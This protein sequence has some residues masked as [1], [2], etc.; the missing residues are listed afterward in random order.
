MSVL[1]NSK[2]IRLSFILINT[3]KSFIIRGCRAT[4]C[5]T[6]IRIVLDVSSVKKASMRMRYDFNEMACTT[7]STHYWAL[8]ISNDLPMFGIKCGLLL[9]FG[10]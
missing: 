1:K 5:K 9:T 10:L 8:E 2:R 3:L 7:N 6:K 4:L